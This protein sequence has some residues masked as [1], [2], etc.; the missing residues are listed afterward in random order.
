LF[1]ISPRQTA[2]QYTQIFAL[3]G[4]G[5]AFTEYGLGKGL[6]FSEC[7]P[8]AILFLDHRNE[9]VHWMQPGDVDLP[10]LLSTEWEQGI[11]DFEPNLPDGFLIAFVDGAVWSIRQDV[12][13]EAISKFFTVESARRFD[14]EEVLGPY[15][16]DK[17]PPLPL[18]R[19]RLE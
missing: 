11:G 2:S 3:A 14:R 17:L 8:D 5:T 12:P 19:R 9:T 7:E 15:T 16:I 4:P 10:R 18:E 1:T 6:D 13:R